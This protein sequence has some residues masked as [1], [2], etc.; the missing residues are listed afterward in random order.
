M[1]SGQLQ[2]IHYR[3]SN[4][5][6]NYP[7]TLNTDGWAYNRDLEINICQKNEENYILVLFIY[8][9]VFIY[10]MMPKGL[11]SHQWSSKGMKIQV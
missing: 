5:F 9:Q 10:M 2:I 4:C 11:N 7:S 3:A 8:L 1:T 6:L